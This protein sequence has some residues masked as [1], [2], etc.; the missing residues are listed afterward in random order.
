MKLVVGW[1]HDFVAHSQN[2]SSAK[3]SCLALDAS[4]QRR[5]D[6]GYSS[7]KEQVR[8]EALAKRA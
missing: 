2:R 5:K 1:M 3:C 7:K 8:M 6:L 4:V